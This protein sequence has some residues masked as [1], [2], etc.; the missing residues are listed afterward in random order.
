MSNRV[1]SNS[2]REPHSILPAG[3]ENGHIRGEYL[4][5]CVSSP[6]IFVKGAG[7]APL[8]PMRMNLDI[9]F[10]GGAG[11]SVAVPVADA[12]VLAAMMPETAR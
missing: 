10:M 1:H 3:W 6:C 2:N 7:K 12:F 11:S 9:S 4:L 5:H 8:L